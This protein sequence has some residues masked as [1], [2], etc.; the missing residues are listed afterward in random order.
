MLVISVLV[1]QIFYNTEIERIED[2]K[3]MLTRRKK[4]LRVELARMNKLLEK[5]PREN[6]QICK[7]KTGT[8]FYSNYVGDDGKRERRYIHKQ[9]KKKIV[10]L[11]LKYYC[12]RR[13][14]EILQELDALE[15]YSRKSMPRWKRDSEELLYYTPGLSELLQQEIRPMSY[16]AKQWAKN[17][18]PEDFHQ[19]EKIHQSPKGLQ[20]RSKAE[21]MIAGCLEDQGIPFRYEERLRFKGGSAL[22]DFTIMHPQ[23]GKKI[24]WEHLGRMDDEDYVSRNLPKLME[25]QA[26]GV[27]LGVNLILTM[28]TSQQPL[29][30]QSIMNIVEAV[31][32]GKS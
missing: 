12:T 28:E 23:T 14:A 3:D 22:P 2:M 4:E 26:N 1:T 16:Q 15:D 17:W 25:Y 24:Y 32:G 30:Y 19:D 18:I 31:I 7:S 29:T 11:G 10:A 21:A 20:V 27:Y 6:L 5:A 13:K 8:Y 9:D